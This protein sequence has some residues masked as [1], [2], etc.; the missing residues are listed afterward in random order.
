M[1]LIKALQCKLFLTELHQRLLTSYFLMFNQ[2]HITRNKQFISRRPIDESRRKSILIAI[3]AI[4]HFLWVS[5]ASL[6]C[7]NTGVIS[8]RKS[9]TKCVCVLNIQCRIGIRQLGLA[10]LKYQTGLLQLLKRQFQTFLLNVIN[11]LSDLGCV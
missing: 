11:L 7:I 5:S 10:Q 2:D 6:L 4:T 1:H 9:F 3:I 8:V